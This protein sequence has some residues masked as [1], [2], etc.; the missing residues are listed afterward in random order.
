MGPFVLRSER[1]IRG[2][3]AGGGIPLRLLL[4]LI[5]V[6]ARL[7]RS[8]IH[9]EFLPIRFC[10]DSSSGDESRRKTIESRERTITNSIHVML[11]PPLTFNLAYEL[12]EAGRQQGTRF[13]CL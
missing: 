11:S 1:Y 7:T 6:G 2:L 3:P 8:Q 12:Y 5:K 9:L 10:E 4:G 13:F